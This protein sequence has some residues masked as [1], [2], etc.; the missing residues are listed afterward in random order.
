L[1]CRITKSGKFRGIFPVFRLGFGNPSQQQ[2][3][4]KTLS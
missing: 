3:N 1:L 2:T 4:F